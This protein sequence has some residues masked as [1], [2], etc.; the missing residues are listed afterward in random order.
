M[1]FGKR[2]FGYYIASNNVQSDKKKEIMLEYTFER[3]I[4]SDN[5]VD[6][7]RPSFKCLL[8][9]L[10]PGDTIYLDSLDNIMSSKAALKDLLVLL[11][12]N[13]VK[14]CILD[15]PSTLTDTFDFFDSDKTSSDFAI[16]I[17]IDM[18]TKE[19]GK[20]KYIAK[21]RQEIGF[22][23]ARKNGVKLG[24]KPKELPETFEQDYKEWKA[25][26]CTAASLYKRYGISNPCFYRKVK[27]YENSILN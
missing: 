4:Y 14:I 17:I 19:A 7:E 26:N 9:L 27:E 5:V 24:R 25:G 18:V 8:G 12:R 10:R 20:E 21:K 13:G 16:D 15:L 2:N 6:S 3:D 22:S 1:P 23:E 11:R